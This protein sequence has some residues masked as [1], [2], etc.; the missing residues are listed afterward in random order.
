MTV[1]ERDNFTRG[2]STQT[3]QARSGD[4]A[5]LTASI[6]VPTYLREGVLIDTL[7]DLLAL[8]P[9]AD[10]ILVIDQTEEHDPATAEFLQ[11]AHT[12]GDIR[13]IQHS[14][15]NLPG[16]RNRALK[17]S[18]CDV[19][20]FVDDD[21][22]PE[23]DFVA[24]HLANY[25]DP[26]VVGVAG[27]VIQVWKKRAG[28]RKRR[29]DLDFLNQ[30]LGSTNRI[31]RVGNFMG[32]NHSV[33]RESMLAIGG[34]DENYL[35]NGYREDTDGAVRLMR[36]YAAEGGRIVFDPRSC[37]T[38][39]QVPSGGCQTRSTSPAVKRPA[40]TRTYGDHYFTYRTFFPGWPFWFLLG[41]NYQRYV[42]N[43][44]HVRAPWRIPGSTI[45]FV[46]SFFKAVAKAKQK[47]R[48]ERAAQ[49][50]RLATGTK[51]VRRGSP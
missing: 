50:A 7:R 31:E 39:L 37:L 20:I 4:T 47:N 28:K 6:A 29:A 3:L 9:R 24:A 49:D 19:V 15:P 32:A 43:K 38:H 8:S 25:T 11:T 12:T 45:S 14:P 10:E 42:I 34:Y 5:Q 13:W 46:I 27:R 48:E 18:T 30:F 36:G 33:R 22:K 51:F 40:W 21:V 44:A 1:A 23:P 26:T 16:A 2:A 17:E 41:R 35:F